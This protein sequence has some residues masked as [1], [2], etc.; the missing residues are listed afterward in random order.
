MHCP[1]C[2]HDATRVIDSRVNPD[3]RGIRRRRECE[4][5]EF[6]FSTQE[7]VLKDDLLIQ[8]RDG[9]R[10]PFD[11]VKV[12]SGINRAMGKRPIE[13]SQIES[14]I[15][16]IERELEEKY[17]DAVPSDAVG[18]KVMEKLKKLDMISYIRFAC[19]YKEFRDIS[20]FEKEFKQLK[21]NVDPKEISKENKKLEK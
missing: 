10:E 1:K 13:P 4:K 16:E 15:D 5:C 21:Q 6:R 3:G 19:V 2:G 11:R 18:K 7:T 20:D 14:M 9:R 8:K 12:L 17:T